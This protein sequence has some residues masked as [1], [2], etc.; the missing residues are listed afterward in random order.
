M[1]GNTLFFRKHSFYFVSGQVAKCQDQILTQKTAVQAVT[2]TMMTPAQAG[3]STFTKRKLETRKSHS[4]SI[5]ADNSEEFGSP[6][7]KRSCQ[8]RKKETLEICREIHGGSSKNKGAALDGLWLTLIK[9][10]TPAKLVKYASRS[11]KNEDK[12]YTQNC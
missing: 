9:E 10:A 1:A 8:R 7:A 6:S 2:G 5:S 12:G 11:K 4:T 3:T